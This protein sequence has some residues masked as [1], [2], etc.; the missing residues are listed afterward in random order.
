MT[1]DD[2]EKL[3]KF[4]LQIREEE[5]EEVEK[6]IV[7]A[8]MKLEAMAGPNMDIRMSGVYRK[9]REDLEEEYERLKIEISRLNAGELPEQHKSNP[10]ERA[11]QNLLKFEEM[12]K[13]RKEKIGNGVNDFND[14]LGPL[15][16]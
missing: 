14:K 6:G 15:K 7:I 16:G 2:K 10:V 8:T 12:A 11:K 3:I 9:R 13:E 1:R 4:M 5:M